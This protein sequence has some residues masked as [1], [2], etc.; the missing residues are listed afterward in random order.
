ML[1]IEEIRKTLKGDDKNLPDEEVRK[2]RDELYGL[3]E[4]VFE[5]W[6]QDQKEK[7]A[8]K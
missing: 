4:I 6:M 8:K 7:R 1:S 3:A 5:K 2:I